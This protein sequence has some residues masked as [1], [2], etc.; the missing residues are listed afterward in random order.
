MHDIAHTGIFS[1]T[2]S[3]AP[4]LTSA[5]RDRAIQAAPPGALVPGVG[6]QVPQVAAELAP[7]LPALL[8]LHLL[9]VLALAVCPNVS[10]SC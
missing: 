1:Q 3:L 5:L 10:Y 8:V 7:Q 9:A 6:G 2:V 4:C